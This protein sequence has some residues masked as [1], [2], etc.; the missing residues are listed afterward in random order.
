MARAAW[1]GIRQRVYERAHGC[2]EYCQT[3]EDNTGQVMQVDHIDPHG[4]DELKNLCLSC[5]SCNNSK[6]RATRVLDTQTGTEVA[7]FNPR[8]QSWDEHF[9]WVE[10]FTRIQGRTAT[11]RATVMR[12]KMNRPALVVARQRWVG[13]GYH[14]PET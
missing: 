9:E 10:E 3:C 12:L 6:R 2:C 7:L 11:G 5:W 4:S 14:P 1:D 8:T 13:G